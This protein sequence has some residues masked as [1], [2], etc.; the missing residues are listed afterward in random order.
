MRG[1]R[2]GKLCFSFIPARYVFVGLTALGLFLVYAFKGF[3][4]VAIV[5]MAT[6]KTGSGSMGMECPGGNTT[7]N[8]NFNTRGEF[9]WDDRAQATIL[10]AYFYGYI[11]LQL[12]AGVLAE[13]FGAKWI[14]GS[15]ML[16]TSLLSMLGPVTARWGFAPFLATRVLQGLAQGVTIP[17]MNAMV[18]RWMPIMERSRGISVIFAGSA[19]GSVVTLPLTGYLCDETFLGGWPAIFYVL[20]TVGIIWCVLWT[21]FVF[22]SPDSHPFI[23]QREYDYICKGQ[24]TFFG[25]S[26]CLIGVIF[27]ECNTTLTIVFF[28]MA[29]GFNGFNYPGYNSNFIDMAPDFSGILQGICNSIGNIPGFVG[30]IVAAEFYSKGVFGFIKYMFINN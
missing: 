22:D 18:A 13:L 4:S 2:E 11:A 17:C 24:G 1:N 27:A 7:T 15:G 9:D 26:I 3:L 5:A 30:P 28:V 12:P 20:G 25:P 8:N 16:I 23:T 21:I 6:R 29:M 19:I 14:F 10:G